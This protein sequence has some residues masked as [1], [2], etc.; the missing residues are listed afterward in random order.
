MELTKPVRLF[1]C[2]EGCIDYDTSWRWQI[3]TAAKVRDGAPEAVALLEHA[4]VFT[5]GR[6]ARYDHL[7][8]QPAEV[9]TLGATIVES[10]RG[11]D[12]TFHGPGQLVAYPI[13]DLRTRGLGPSAYVRR[14]EEAIIRTL[15]EFGVRGER[16]PGRPGVWV[17][18]AKIAAIGVRVHGGISTHGL[19]LNVETDLSWF[20]AIVPCGISDAAV[21]SLARLME[22]S[23]GVTTVVDD[24]CEAFA[25][26][27]D[28]ELVPCFD[29]PRSLPQVCRPAR[30]WLDATDA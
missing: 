30:E 6:R 11:G 1:R 12:V 22:H 18:G 27:F 5:F 25:A 23:P 8:V 24:F 10:D 28:S 20:R 13:L 14:L 26:V 19:A 21:T 2:S 17:D 7:L 16:S 15:H 29:S 3:A 4:P 9:Q